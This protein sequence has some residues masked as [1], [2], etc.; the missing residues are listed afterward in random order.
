MQVQL[1]ST[2]SYRNQYQ[3]CIKPELNDNDTIDQLVN[4]YDRFVGILS[5]SAQAT[6]PK[7][8]ARAK[9]KWMA[10]DNFQ[11][12]G[13]RRLAKSD[14]DKYNKLDAEIRREC[15]TAKELMLLINV[16]RFSNWTQHTSQT[17]CTLRLDRVL[18]ESQV[19][20]WQHVLRTKMV[21]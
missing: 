6:L 3:Q 7:R 1:P 18:S 4:R 11:K 13:R 8:K 5:T 9:Q 15:Q 12:M 19:H 16:R 14:V 10:S 21:T 2:D 20:V 17:R